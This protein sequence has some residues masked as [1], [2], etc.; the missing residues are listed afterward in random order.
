MGEKVK[1][2]TPISALAVLLLTLAVMSLQT[3]AAIMVLIEKDL[4]HTNDRA[5]TRLWST[6]CA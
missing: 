1:I 2:A 3:S 5:P 4:H 6:R